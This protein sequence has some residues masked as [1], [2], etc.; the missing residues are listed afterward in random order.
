MDLLQTILDAGNGQVVNQLG[1]QFGL[2]RDRT[3]AALEQLVPALAAGV[4]RNTAQPGGLEHL[5]GALAGGGHQQ[6]LDDPSQLGRAETV[7][8]GNGILGHILGSKDVSRGVATHAA[9]RTGIDADVLKRMLPIVASIAMGAMSR[10][11]TSSPGA[12]APAATGGGLLD[13][14]TPLLDQN[15]DG[16]VADDVLG[17]L[18]RAFRR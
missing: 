18:G 9:A 5:L 10:R 3:V 17:M 15:R 16:S 11:A 12:A 6:Y 4:S 7:Q 2:D 1:G 13:M 8:D 14:L